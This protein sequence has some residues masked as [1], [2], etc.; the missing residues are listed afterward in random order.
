MKKP[1]DLRVCDVM[2]RPNLLGPYFRGDSWNRWRSIIKATFAEPMT[3]EEIA[4]FKEVAGGREPPKRRVSEA[5]YAVGRG[6]G[7]DAIASLIATSIAV[8]FDGKNKLRPGEKA[9]IVCIA[10][11]RDQAGV[12][13]NYIKGYFEEVAALAALI[14]SID[15]NGVTLKN[16]V[17]ITVATNSFRSVRGRSIICAIFDECAFWRSE[18]SAVPDIEVAGAIAPGLARMPGSMLILISSVYK[19]SGLLFQRVRDNFGKDSDDTLAVLGS[20]PQF[21][22]LFDTRIIERQIAEDGPR[23][24]AEYNSIW[25]DDLAS[26]IGR[27][28][29]EAAVDS[30]VV[31]RPPET[32]TRYVAFADAS[33]GRVDSFTAAVAHATKDGIVVLDASL[34][35]KPPHNPTQVVEEIVA[36]AKSYGC[37]GIVGDNYGAGLT[38]EMFARAGM[39][40]TKSERDRSAIYLDMLP[41]FA[42]GRVRLLDNKR[43]VSQ[44]SELERRT[45]PTGRDVVRK[46]PGSHDDVCN[47]A[48]GALVLAA[49]RKAPMVITDAAIA[50]A[51]TP[52][53]RSPTPADPYRTF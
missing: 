27:E 52:D 32:A 22:P 48:A 19:R 46:G 8:N 1:L 6:G 24:Q 51:S 35:R 20:T 36:L 31:V 37:V 45:F 30:G 26:F 21:N 28:L 10:V 40:Y 49:S 25:R 43:L 39:K 13:A 23:Y 42:S 50:W 53:R 44:F 15:R 9:H 16:G 18:D 3:A 29:I 38:V 41:L 12:V 33:G 34:E 4:D 2:S 5:V 14:K 47:S 7:K 17:V 11:D